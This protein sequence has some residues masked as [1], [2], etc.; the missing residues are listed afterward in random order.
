MVDLRRRHMEVLKFQGEQLSET[1]KVIYENG[2]MLEQVNR[3]NCR[4]HVVSLNFI[5]IGVLFLY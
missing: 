5:W 3:E 4:L 2:L 1:E